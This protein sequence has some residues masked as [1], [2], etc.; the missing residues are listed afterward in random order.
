MISQPIDQP[1]RGDHMRAS[2]G[3]RVAE[4]V[5]ECADAIDTLRGPGGL[6][7]FREPSGTV[8]AP[9]TCR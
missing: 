4:R 6:F 1:R 2:W 8:L 3:A 7:S 5:N 9:F